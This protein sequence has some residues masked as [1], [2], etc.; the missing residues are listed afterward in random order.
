MTCGRVPFPMPTGRP[1]GQIYCSATQSCLAIRAAFQCGSGPGHILLL[2]SSLSEPRTV[3]PIHDPEILTMTTG[4]RNKLVSPSRMQ[5]NLSAGRQSLPDHSSKATGGVPSSERGQPRAHLAISLV[6]QC[7]E[8][9]G[10]V[11]IDHGREQC[12]SLL[13]LLMEPAQK[14]RKTFRNPP[15][16]RTGHADASWGSAFPRVCGAIG[17]QRRRIPGRQVA[18]GTGGN[19]M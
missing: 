14:K 19:C 17:R 18:A 16:A 8:E 13:L 9:D 5:P 12:R 10:R 6:S 7:A 4:S 2:F 3:E 15:I 1:A 11:K